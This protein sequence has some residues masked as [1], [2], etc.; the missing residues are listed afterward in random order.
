MHATMKSRQGEH[1]QQRAR[2][3]A[4][5][6]SLQGAGQQMKEAAVRTMSDSRQFVEGGEKL[7]QFDQRLQRMIAQQDSLN[8]KSDQLERQL[9]HLR[10]SESTLLRTLP[11]GGRGVR[12]ENSAAADIAT[13]LPPWD[14]SGV[15]AVAGDWP[16]SPTREQLGS[17][18][19]STAGGDVLTPPRTPELI[20]AE[21]KAELKAELRT[22]L[23]SDSAKRVRSYG[24]R[25]NV[26]RNK[27][28]WSPPGNGSSPT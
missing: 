25:N 6:R 20:K 14:A 11:S 19:I 17:S 5:C 7:K 28:A 3:A 12:G 10:G 9:D 18:Q 22:E 23:M 15:A 16:P 1:D 13:Q 4:R 26:R 27:P 2:L 8:E 24:V 21:I